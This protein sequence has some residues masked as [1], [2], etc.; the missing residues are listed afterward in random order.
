[1]GADCQSTTCQVCT[2]NSVAGEVRLDTNRLNFD[3][4]DVTEFERRVKKFAFANPDGS[5]TL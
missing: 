2:E 3:L 1:M 5:V 4:M